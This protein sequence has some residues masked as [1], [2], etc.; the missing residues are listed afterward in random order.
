MRFRILALSLMAA[1]PAQAGLIDGDKMYQYCVNRSQSH[2]R[3]FLTAYV[4][5]VV[6][7]EIAK[8]ASM[9]HDGKFKSFCMPDGV[10]LGKLVDLSCGVTEKHPNMRGGGANYLVTFA[11][12]QVW[13]C[14]KPTA[15]PKR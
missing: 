7:A 5:G 6:D 15:K 2:D 9:D 12:G 3:L 11:L 14:P 1:C 13:P 10:E 8:M 4:A